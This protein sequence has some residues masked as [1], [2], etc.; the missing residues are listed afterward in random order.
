MRRGALSCTRKRREGPLGRAE[1]GGRTATKTGGRLLAAVLA[2]ALGVGA[3]AGCGSPEQGEVLTLANIG[4]DENVA[5]SSLTKVLLED[6]LGYERVEV[7]TSQD[8]DKTYRRVASGELDAF[9]DVWLPNHEDLLAGVAGDVEHLD[10][11]FLGETKQ[12]MAVPAYMDVT[13]IG[14]LEGTD[15]EFIFGI[16]PSS[17]VMREVV[18]GDA[19]GVISAYGLD[20]QLVQA[21][22]AGMLEE[23]EKRYRAREEFAFLAWSPHW[24]NWRFDIRYLDDPKDA[25]GS[26]N[27]PAEVSTIVRGYLREEDPVAHAFVDALALTEGQ[28][29]GLEQ[30]INEEGDPIAGARRWASENRGVVRPWVEAARDA[31]EE[32]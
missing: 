30:A 32:R 20:Q 12:G 1:L 17:A 22:T 31:G 13:S 10:P 8:L 11:W 23:V 28:I 9:Q 24:M 19:G 21:P 7:R 3:W 2:L 27:D 5:V 6:K 14:Q 16:E 18:G 29:N 25:M 4:W 15:A 26:T